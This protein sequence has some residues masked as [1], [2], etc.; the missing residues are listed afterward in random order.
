MRRPLFLYSAYWQLGF[1]PKRFFEELFATAGVLW[2]FIEVVSYFSPDKTTGI[3]SWWW[4]LFLIGFVVALIRAKP[5]LRASYKLEGRDIVFEIIVGDIWAMQG[6]VVISA[7]TTFDTD[8]SLISSDS[9]QGQFTDNC[10]TSPDHLAYD[11][12]NQLQGVQGL[13]INRA[14]QEL[15]DY[16][17]GTVVRVNTR[18]RAAYL[19]ALT[20]LNEYGNASA[21][22][23]DLRVALPSLWA[24]ISERGNLSSILVPVIGGGRARIPVSRNLLVQE[25]VVSAIAAASSARFCEK[26]TIVISP[27]DFKNLRVD[28]RELAD[29]IRLNCRF[30]QYRSDS[31]GRA[32]SGLGMGPI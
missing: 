23:E 3:R 8:R 11:L 10:Y 9:L 24:Y 19:L 1:S 32:G 26:L 6:E 21:S 15:V 4:V 31:P 7:P 5:L 28:L 18:K 20:H 25:I 22:I 12:K 30:T 16:P 17:V 29:F 2:F 14:G 13:A 27:K